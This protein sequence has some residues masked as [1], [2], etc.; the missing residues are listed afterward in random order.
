MNIGLG[1]RTLDTFVYTRPRF[2]PQ[3]VW[4]DPPVTG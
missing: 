1:N 4:S 2:A 3:L